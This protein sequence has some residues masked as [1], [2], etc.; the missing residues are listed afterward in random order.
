MATCH[1]A[2]MKPNMPDIEESKMERLLPAML[3]T[4]G[5]FAL[6]LYFIS[7]ALFSAF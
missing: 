1:R 5:G 2:Q 4:L 6:G 3:I 7:Q